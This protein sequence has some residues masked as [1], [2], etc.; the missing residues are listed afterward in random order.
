[1]K[2]FTIFLILFVVQ[3]IEASS[4]HHLT[5]M[6]EHAQQNHQTSIETTVGT[7]VYLYF[8]GPL[9]FLSSFG[10]IW[11]NEKRAAI[12]AKRLQIGREICQDFDVNNLA[13]ARSK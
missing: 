7:W 3:M 1:M 4:A 8:L 9:L 10:T 5:V 12:D 2:L 13:S 6:E 11:F